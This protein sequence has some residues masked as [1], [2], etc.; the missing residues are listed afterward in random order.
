MIKLLTMDL[1]LQKYLLG[2]LA[3]LRESFNTGALIVDMQA[4]A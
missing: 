4:S 2:V 1:E 3:C